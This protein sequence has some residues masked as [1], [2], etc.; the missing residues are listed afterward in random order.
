MRGHHERI[1]NIGI[2]RK[3]TW[4]HS[5]ISARSSLR[6]TLAVHA[7]LINQ[8]P[9]NHTT[10]TRDESPHHLGIFIGFRITETKTCNHRPFDNPPN[11]PCQDVM[12]MSPRRWASANPIPRDSRFEPTATSVRPQEVLQQHSLH[13]Q[14]VS[15]IAW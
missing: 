10:L 1:M 11:L 7:T 8:L 13:S 12:C 2:D 6:L 3:H 15:R 14:V 5:K 9:T 4:M